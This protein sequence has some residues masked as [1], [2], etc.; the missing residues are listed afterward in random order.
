MEAQLKKELGTSMLKSTG[1]SG[2]GC[3]SQGQSFDTDHGGV[4]VKTNHKSQAKRMFDGELASLGAIVMTDTVK[5]PKPVKVIELDTGGAVFV[6][7]HVDMRGLSRHSKQLGERLADLHLHNQIRRDR[8]N[9]EQQTVGKGADV[10]VIDQFGFQVPTCC[11]YLPQEN[12][13]PPSMA[14]LSTSW[15]S[16]GCSEGSAT[17]STLGTTTRSP[18]PRGL[19]R[20]ISCINCSTI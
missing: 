14:T 19:R 18:R 9:K 17:P 11:G 15:A 1:H 4:F 16:P 10:P 5:V 2:G 12:E 8:Q 20:G 3:I 13:W 7:E 6:M